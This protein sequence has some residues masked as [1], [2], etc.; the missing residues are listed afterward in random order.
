MEQTLIQLITEAAIGFLHSVNW[1]F[2][3]VFTL[4]TWLLNEGTDHPTSFKWLNWLQSVSK[5]VR[6]L[7]FGLLLAIPF[8]WLYE[9][10]TKEDFTGLIY[11]IFIGMAVWK[12]GIDWLIGW[13]KKNIFKVQDK[14][15]ETP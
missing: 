6:A 4:L 11:A 7:V 5:P 9:C 3:V 12:L 2:V 13:V 15:A 8:A 10:K 14:V 1:I